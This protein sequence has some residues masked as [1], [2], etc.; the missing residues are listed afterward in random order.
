MEISLDKKISRALA[1]FCGSTDVSRYMTIETYIQNY[2]SVSQASPLEPAVSQLSMF[3]NRDFCFWF[4]IPRKPTGSGPC[5]G[6]VDLAVRLGF[7]LSPS[8]FFQIPCLLGEGVDPVEAGT[9][10]RILV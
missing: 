4:I 7:S 3:K 6:G 8:H 1:C 10:L 5:D 2:I 9:K